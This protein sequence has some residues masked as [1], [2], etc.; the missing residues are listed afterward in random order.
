MSSQSDVAY[1]KLLGEIRDGMLGPGARLT[2]VELAG[3]LSISRTPVREA[4]RQLEADGLVEHRPHAGAVVRTL[5]YAEITE[6]YA[7]RAVLES[8]V[9]RMAALAASPIELEALETLNAEMAAP[10]ADADERYRLNNQFHRALLDVAKN[11]FLTRAMDSVEKTLLIL[12]PSTLGEFSRAQE[13]VDEHA[14]VLEAIRARD[15]ETA[16]REMRH[17]IEAAHR[18]RLQQL[19]ERER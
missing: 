13:A 1:Q 8:T 6:L 11:R 10:S 17:H 12:G 7:M 14:R 18:I 3:R 5:S 19:R 15:A 2:E 9:A 4:I 16:E